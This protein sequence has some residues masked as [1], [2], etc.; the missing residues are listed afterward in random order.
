[1]NKPTFIQMDRTA[2]DLRAIREAEFAEDCGRAI[3]CEGLAALSIS[4]GLVCQFDGI[5]PMCG[6][7]ARCVVS[8]QFSL[9]DDPAKRDLYFAV[10]SCQDCGAE[11]VWNARLKQGEFSVL[12]VMAYTR[13]PSLLL[14]SLEDVVSLDESAAEID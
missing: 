13:L 8:G 3:V 12:P 2:M 6:K 11:I 14:K 10:T 5:C 4:R 7:V 1:M 9:D